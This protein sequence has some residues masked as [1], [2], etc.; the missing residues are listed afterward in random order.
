MRIIYRVICNGS[1]HYLDF[2][3]YIFMIYVQILSNFRNMNETQY[4][5]ITSHLGSPNHGFCAKLSSPKLLSQILKML[6][7]REDATIAV[8]VNG[9]KITAEVSKSFQANA[10][11]QRE[12]FLEYKVAKEIEAG[13]EETVFNVSMTTLIHCLNLCGAGTGATVNSMSGLPTSQT[14][15]VISNLPTSSMMLYYSDL[16]DPLRIW[17]EEDG[18]ISGN[19]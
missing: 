10:F 13:E 1:S 11:I 5:E 8:G 14:N 2:I 9:L 6:S 4:N 3:K 18:V 12:T 19:T 17:L 7:F 15:M 16:G